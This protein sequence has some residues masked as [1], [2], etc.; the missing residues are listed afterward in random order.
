MINFS[1]V[2]DSARE[3]PVPKDPIIIPTNEELARINIEYQPPHLSPTAPTSSPSTSPHSPRSVDGRRGYQPQRPGSRPSSVVVKKSLNVENRVLLKLAN[4]LPQ[5]VDSLGRLPESRANLIKLNAELDEMIIESREVDVKERQFSFNLVAT[6]DTLPADPLV[7][8]MEHKG[9]MYD[10]I[11]T[12]LTIQAI[13][14]AGRLHRLLN[15][16]QARLHSREEEVAILRQS[17]EELREQ[18]A[19]VRGQEGQG[20]A[21]EGEKTNDSQAQDPSKEVEL[22]SLASIT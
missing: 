4:N 21:E 20:E 14:K 17:V 16:Q 15:A 19:S 3:S 5:T 22:P 13:R 6:G 9:L 8:Q 18:L 11:V 10:M 2:T 1:N 7:A 12:E